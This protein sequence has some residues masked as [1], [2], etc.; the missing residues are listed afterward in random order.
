[1]QRGRKG[2]LALARRELDGVRH[3]V[4]D[5]LLQA[6]PIRLYKERLP[7]RAL[8]GQRQ[9]PFIVSIDL[10]EHRVHDYLLGRYLLVEDLFYLTQRHA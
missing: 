6:F 5:N 7:A 4:D 3:Q 2:D 10:P 1:M 8:F 9:L